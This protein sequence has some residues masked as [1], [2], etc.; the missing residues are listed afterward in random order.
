[1][2][3]T[4]PKWR[5][6]GRSLGL[7]ARELDHIEAELDRSPND[8]ELAILAGM[9]SEHCS[10]KS[11]R[12][13]LATLPR[14]GERVLAGPG[15]HAGVVDVG[16][17][18]AL[19][20]KIESHNH[21]SAVEPFQGAATGV[22]GILRDIIAEGARPCAVMDYLCFG[23]PTS[24]RTQ[25]IDAGVVEGIAAYGNA[26][27]VANVGGRLHLDERY[28]GSPL[29]NVL[30]AGLLRPDAL[31]HNRAQGIGNAVLY[32]GA[33]TGRDG[34]Q[35]AS[36]AS[37]EL[38]AD[39]QR[40]RSHV[41][42]GDPFAGKKLMEACLGLTQEMGLLACQ[43]L[44]ASGLA[45]A[46]FE[47][48][49]A[50][51]TGMAIDLDAVPLREAN[52]S[53]DEVLLS[54]S[55]ERFLFVVAAGREEAAIEH[56]QRHGLH[57][58]VLG[59][60]TNSGRLRIEQRGL[61]VADLPP[62]LVAGGAPASRWQAAVRPP[63]V[64]CYPDFDAPLD[65][66]PALVALLSMPELADSE[67][68]FAHYD[69]TV[70]NRTVYG[71]GEAEAA[72][73]SL[74][75]SQR[76]VA[77]CL[78]G[79]GD[80]G[81]VDAFGAA[82]AALAEACLD[83]A[84][85]G[86]TMV[87][88][89][90][91]LNC[92]SPDKPREY[93]QVLDTVSGLR[94]GLTALGV[95]VTGGN[96]SLYNESPLGAVPPTL[97]VGGLGLVED[98]EHAPR[99]RLFAGDALLLLGPQL[100]VPT[101]SRYGAMRTGS[102]G[103]PLAAVDLGLVHRLAAFLVAEVQRGHV[104]GAKASGRGGLAVALAKLCRSSGC[105]AAVA[106]AQAGRPDWLLFGEYTGQVWVSVSPAHVEAVAAAARAAN[107]PCWLAGRAGDEQLLIAGCLALPLAALR[108]SP[109]SEVA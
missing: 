14:T 73:L 26:F 5:T 70:G 67:R 33:T 45:C 2:T 20:F 94:D 12:H 38:A 87:A 10:Y 22:G 100:D 30:A 60:I 83:L 101:A 104:R 80:Y 32:V 109:S 19:A 65:L 8:V 92:G 25:H 43:D 37:R 98:I 84:C 89:T 85:V 16:D 15:A 7:S 107:V 4:E 95:P 9:W 59:R 58:A 49:A 90:D 50:R 86:A 68:V 63:H 96:V 55:Q 24:S 97:V 93:R 61:P 46:L 44:G 42:V 103:G 11:T 105:G 72:L 3:Q 23:K 51:A 41:Q 47:M 39:E 64:L 78:A 40:Q 79:R 54:E 29:V 69:Q 53:A 35:G 1:V 6:R 18:W 36:F 62:A 77:L 99:A 75:D 102:P 81:A 27:G 106:L 56:F 28:E 48:A 13:L 82:Q 57:A 108:V 52:L 88:I 76:G 66:A 71:P 31:R 91:G 34:I 21:P 17:G 74:P